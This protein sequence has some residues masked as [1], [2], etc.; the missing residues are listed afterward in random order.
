MVSLVPLLLLAP[1]P[2]RTEYFGVYL[3]GVKMGYVVN[4]ETRDAVNG[5]PSILRHSHTE[6]MQVMG[7]VTLKGSM[8]DRVWIDDANHPLRESYVHRYAQGFLRI[9]AVFTAKTVELDTDNGIKKVH[10]SVPLPKEEVLEDYAR[11]VRDR[12]SPGKSLTFATF[13]AEDGAF[14]TSTMSCVGPSA[15][16]T[17]GRKFPATLSELSGGGLKIRLYTDAQGALVR[18]EMS[19]KAFLQAEPKEIA[20][21]Q[22]KAADQPDLLLLNSLH[23]KTPLEN[24]Q[25]LQRLKL[26]FEGEDFSK[27]PSDDFQTVTRDGDGWLVD[28]HPPKIADSNPTARIGDS[29]NGQEAWLAPSEDLSCDDPAIREAAKKA[30]GNVDT[31]PSAVLAIRKYVSRRM[32]AKLEFGDVRDAADILKNPHGKCVE[33]AVLT[34]ALL[35]A[36]GIPARIVSGLVTADGTF[37]YHAWSEAWDGRRWIGVDAALEVDQ[38]GACYVKLAQGDVKDGF[39]IDYPDDPPAVKIDVVPQGK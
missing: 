26:R 16:E 3:E 24:P 18:N 22:P 19:P 33:Y 15:Y 12:L 23:T 35:R 32:K 29:T 10:K 2:S 36:A 17:G 20:L 5:K 4:T 21:S 8:D 6:V 7:G 9:E 25:S 28:I 34:T 14:E 39:K 13:N 37:F 31:V 38:M 11:I 1:A 30:I 27:I